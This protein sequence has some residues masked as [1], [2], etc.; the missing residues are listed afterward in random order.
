M[1][2]WEGRPWAR[3]T[4]G[5]PV[6]IQTSRLRRR[7][8]QPDPGL[9][10]GTTAVEPPRSPQ[11]GYSLTEDL[12][13]HRSRVRQQKALLPDNRSSTRPPPTPH[14]V[15]EEW[16]DKT[17]ACSTM[18]GMVAGED[19]AEQKKLGVVPG[20]AELTARHDEIPA[21]DEMPE[22]LKPVL[23]RQMEIYAG[24]L[25][26]TDHEI[27]RLVDAISNSIPTTPYTPRRHA[28]P[29]A[30]STALQRSPPD[31]GSTPEFLFHR[32]SPRAPPG[33]ARAVHAVQWPTG[34][35]WGTN[36]TSCTAP[37]SRRGKVRSSSTISL[38][39]PEAAAPAPTGTVARP[40]EAAL[41]TLPP[42][43][44]PRVQSSI[45]NPLTPAGGGASPHP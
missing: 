19:H 36:G 34:P 31:P 40:A 29:R 4:S 2:G 7:R 20:D 39:A 9:Y 26:Q 17:R 16:S 18:A 33:G 28:P 41:G 25:E 30:R 43:A 14:Q 6:G 11:E 15:S 42:A 10:E 38:P 37:V 8:G 32:S 12:A 44:E 3:S 21:W 35:A 13:D 22:E 1:P 5:R 24:F 27:G 45:G 23:A